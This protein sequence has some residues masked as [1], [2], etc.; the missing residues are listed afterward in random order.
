[1][2]IT[3]N[4]IAGIF[5]SLMQFFFEFARATDVRKIFLDNVSKS[6]FELRNS[7]IIFLP[8]EILKE[9]KTIS[10]F[11]TNFTKVMKVWLQLFRNHAI[12][13][14]NKFITTNFDLQNRNAR[15]SSTYLK[16]RDLSFSEKLPDAC[17]AVINHKKLMTS[18]SRNL[19]KI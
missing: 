19:K 2:H 17:E 15:L 12:I 6:L 9:Q 8:A 10:W 7:G 1:M 16:L 3:L 11:A 13:I 5:K 4:A 14:E 18:N